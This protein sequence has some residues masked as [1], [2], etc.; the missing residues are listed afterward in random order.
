MHDARNVLAG[1]QAWS[2]Q[3]R[4]K[5]PSEAAQNVV[6]LVEQLLGEVESQSVLLRAELGDLRAH[7]SPVGACGFRRARGRRGDR[8]LL[9]REGR[10]R[11]RESERQ[12]RASFPL[13]PVSNLGLYQ[14]VWQSLSDGSFGLS[15]G[16]G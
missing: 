12:P 10:I 16:L 3:L 5:T 6:R 9:L 11:V 7:L 2:E 13:Y 1:L 8:L 14:A 15:N 4:E